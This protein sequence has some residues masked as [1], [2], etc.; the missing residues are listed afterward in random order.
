MKDKFKEYLEGASRP[1]RLRA[2]TVKSYKNVDRS[3]DDR[4]TNSELATLGD[5]LL[6]Y[7][8]SELLF[9]AEVENITVEKKK[10]ET[11]RVLVEVIAK[12]YHLLKYI[13]Y[14]QGNRSIPRTYRYCEKPGNDSP[15]KYI[16]TTVEALLA[17]I[18]LDHGKYGGDGIRLVFEIV[19]SWKSLVDK[20][21]NAKA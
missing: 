16:A 4:D 19:R 3:L 11:D 21:R 17:A 20:S 6:K 13:R 18:Y 10:Y 9:E 8:L 14:D 5:A 15:H 2:L 12:H 7:A 1:T